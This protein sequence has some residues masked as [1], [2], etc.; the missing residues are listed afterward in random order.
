MANPI[1]FSNDELT[2]LNAELKAKREFYIKASHMNYSVQ[3]A[4][5]DSILKKIDDALMPDVFGN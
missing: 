1:T 5:I 2:F 3:L 4:A